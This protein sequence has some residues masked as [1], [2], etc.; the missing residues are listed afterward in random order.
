[1]H[2]GCLYEVIASGGQT[3]PQ[4]GVFAV[5]CP[6]LKFWTPDHNSGTTKAIQS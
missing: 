3:V 4:M 1:M 5:T 6:M 2:T